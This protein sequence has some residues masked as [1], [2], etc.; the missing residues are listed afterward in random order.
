MNEYKWYDGDLIISSSNYNIDNNSSDKKTPP[1][2]FIIVSIIFLVL[3]ILFITTTIILGSKFFSMN[4]NLANKLNNSLNN[5]NNSITLTPSDA[6][7]DEAKAALNSVVNIENSDSFG[8]FFG[9][10]FSL[11]EGSGVIVHEDGYILTSLYIVENTGTVDVKLND[12]TTHKAEIFSIDSKTNTAILKIDATGLTPMTLGDSSE[13]KLGDTVIAIGNCINSN[14]SNPVTIGSISGIDNI[15]LQNDQKMNVLQVDASSLANS[16]GG[17]VLNA[18][19]ELIGIT[20]AMI[21]NQSSEIGIVTPIND[22][23]ESLQNLTSDETTNDSELTI[24]ISGTDASYGVM[25]DSIGEGTPAE[26]A[27]M[28]IGDLIIKVNNE[29]VTSIKKI[30]EIKTKHKKGDT[31]IFTIYRE[32][33]VHE[34]KIVLE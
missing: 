26:K 8:G 32:G 22:L 6:N 23:K 5:N 16:I 29:S 14:L 1:R 27:G 2:W 13:V 10:S 7:V 21:S 15:S 34:I 20:T 12:G 19:G 18:K 9:H 17:L 25:V 4:S 3:L 24:G 33:E 11:G 31:L 28:Q 30:N